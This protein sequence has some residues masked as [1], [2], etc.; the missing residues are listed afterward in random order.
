MNIVLV[1][2]DALQADHLSCYGYE[3]DTSPHLD[4]FARNHTKY[5]SAIAPS[6]WTRSVAASILTGTYPSVHGVQ[7]IS[8]RFPTEPICFPSF[9]Q[10]NDYYTVGISGIGNVSSGLGFDVGFNEFVDLYKDESLLP[11]RAS[12]NAEKEMLNHES[13]E[14]IFPRAEDIVDRFEETILSAEGSEP[15]FSLLWMIDPHDPYHP[16]EQHRPF[17]NSAYEGEIEGSR[18]SIRRASSQEDFQRL[19]DLYDSEISYLDTQFARLVQLLKRADIWEETVLIFVGDHGEAFGDHDGNV[20]HSNVHYEELIHVPCLIRYPKNEPTWDGTEELIN[21]ADILPTVLDY[22]GLTMDP[23]P[24]E[25]VT[26]DSVLAGGHEET[27]TETQ[28]SK[29][30][31]NYYSI[32]QKRWKY[33]TVNSPDS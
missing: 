30:Q 3:R 10:E 4:R 25:D 2:A 6:T 19:I 23:F 15:F 14:V 22:V 12:S 8:D 1:V 28:Y 27:F 24:P 20:G 17:V 26:G 31:N 7:T 11:D 32:R 18:E 29:A 13:G 5:E 16:P 21:L 33:I 9:L